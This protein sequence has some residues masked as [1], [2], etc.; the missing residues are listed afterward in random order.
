MTMPE[1]LVINYAWKLK[2]RCFP[3]SEMLEVHL[4]PSEWGK[5]WDF[6]EKLQFS[7]Y[8]E[9]KYI[10]SK[11]YSFCTMILQLLFLGFVVKNS[12]FPKVNE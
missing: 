9:L 7:Y 3:T 5:Q 6:Y 2:E 11:S 10:I 8:L 1:F 4:K 12:S